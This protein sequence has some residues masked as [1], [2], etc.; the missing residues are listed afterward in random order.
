MNQDN[1]SQRPESV[2]QAFL[3][4]YL[5]LNGLCVGHCT[6]MV[7]DMMNNGYNKNTMLVLLLYVLP[8]TIS[9]K[10][11]IEIWKSLHNNHKQNQ[12]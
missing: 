6:N 8:I 5:L 3:M 12:K 2:S 1:K 11:S 7:K 9:A 10:R 4:G